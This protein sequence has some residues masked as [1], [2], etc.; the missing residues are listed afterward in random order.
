[1]SYIKE[2][3][4]EQENARRENECLLRDEIDEVTEQIASKQAQLARLKAELVEIT[5]GEP[6]QAEVNADENRYMDQQR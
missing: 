4:I 2:K 3:F 6:T 5:G 1:M